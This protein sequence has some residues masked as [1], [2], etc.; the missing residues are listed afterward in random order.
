MITSLLIAPVITITMVS[1][2]I[3]SEA[4]RYLAGTVIFRKVA[5]TSPVLVVV[6]IAI[7][8]G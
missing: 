3:S 7:F 4:S 6:S 2:I 1:T 8:F 5:E